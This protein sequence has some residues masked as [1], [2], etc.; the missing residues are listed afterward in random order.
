MWSNSPSDLSNPWAS[1]LCACQTSSHLIVDAPGPGLLPAPSGTLIIETLVVKRDRLRYFLVL[2]F[3]WSWFTT[4][5]ADT[6][7]HASS[8]PSA[9][10]NNCSTHQ[11]VHWKASAQ[12][13]LQ[14]APVIVRPATN[15]SYLDTIVPSDKY[16][17]GPVPILGVQLA[18]AVTNSSAGAVFSH[19]HLFDPPTCSLESTGHRS[20]TLWPNHSSW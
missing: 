4:L 13:I 2:F 8:C 5:K 1:T 16:I 20:V 18:S 15:M 9:T 3:P 11:H 7:D 19:Q 17:Y 14:R 12:Y 6:F 10:T